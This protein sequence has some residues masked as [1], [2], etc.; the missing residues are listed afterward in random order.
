M[1]IILALCLG[2]IIGFILGILHYARHQKEILKA[3]FKDLHDEQVL[4]WHHKNN[5]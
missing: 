2:L 5:K 4:E 1:S 3:A